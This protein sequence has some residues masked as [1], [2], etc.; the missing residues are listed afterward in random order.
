MRHLPI[1]P[2][3]SCLSEKAEACQ[4]LDTQS[5]HTYRYSIDRMRRRH[6]EEVHRM[7]ERL[8]KWS[9]QGLLIMRW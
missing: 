6:V 7:R 3:V 9:L 1:A 8:Q 4:H 2:D 5:R